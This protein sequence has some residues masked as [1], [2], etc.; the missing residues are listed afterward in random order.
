MKIS[1]D[2]AKEI[3]NRDIY[4]YYTDVYNFKHVSLID[5][6]S[7]F[8]KNNLDI[9]T[10]NHNVTNIAF[11]N[12]NDN[13]MFTISKLNAGKP[14]IVISIISDYLDKIFLEEK[15]NLFI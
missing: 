4:Q 8:F 9:E 15:I 11:Y 3:L 6:I 10:V 2:E 7:N 14:K 13:L 12:C 5:T 1:I